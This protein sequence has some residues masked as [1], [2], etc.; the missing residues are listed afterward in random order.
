[1]QY[2]KPQLYQLVWDCEQYGLSEAEALVYIRMRYGKKISPRSYYDYKKEIDSGEHTFQWLNDF[3]RVGFV[4]SHQGLIE[5]TRRILKSS[6]R[7]LLLEERKEHPDDHL[8]VKLKEDIRQSLKLLEGFNLGTPVI[9]AIRAQLQN[10]LRTDKE[11]PKSATA[12]IPDI[13]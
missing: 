11:Q 2:K 7:R 5:N 1:M 12:T 9:S 13:E 4:V 3:T 6:N 8:I 10:E